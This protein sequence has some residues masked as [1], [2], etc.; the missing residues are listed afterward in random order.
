MNELVVI[1]CPMSKKT[2]R[3]IP[4]F[5]GIEWLK[6]ISKQDYDNFA[7]HIN[8]NNLDN[9]I[10][11]KVIEIGESILKDRFTFSIRSYDYPI[12]SREPSRTTTAINVKQVPYQHF[13]DI[14]NDLTTDILD[15]YPESKYIMSL[16]S[17]ILVHP[18]TISRMV[19]VYPRIPD[20]AMLGIPV[21]NGRR[22]TDDNPDGFYHG[23]AQYNFGRIVTWDRYDPLLTRFR[24]MRAYPTDGRLF[25]VG[26]TGAACMMDTDIIRKHIP[27]YG[28][29]PQGEDCYACHNVKK[30][31]YTI[32]IDTSHVTLHMMEPELWKKDI[33]KFMKR[34][35]I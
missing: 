19:D 27:L 13:A 22:T 1:G 33:E 26:Y 8:I 4:H 25:E 17:D 20:I 30:N 34:E 12:D 6:S 7:V 16:D 10:R 28:A 24:S 31:G 18:D 2:V 29:H 11:D 35:I 32:W 23:Y 14:R 3:G 15:K 21:N 5:T 9:D